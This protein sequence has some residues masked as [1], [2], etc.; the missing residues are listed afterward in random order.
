VEFKNPL[1]KELE[2]AVR[3]MLLEWLKDPKELAK[4]LRLDPGEFNKYTPE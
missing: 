4:M 3:S 2:D 1:D